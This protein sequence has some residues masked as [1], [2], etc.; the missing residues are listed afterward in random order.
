M[1]KGLLI[2]DLY[3]LK[4]QIRF[5][6]YVTLG[7]IYVSSLFV[8]SSRYGNAALMF[9]DEAV[10]DNADI[11]MKFMY[12]LIIV[13]T[14]FI[15]IALGE[16]V[17]ECFTADYKASF[18]KVYFNLP[19]DDYRKVLSRYIMSLIYI[20]MGMLGSFA[21]GCILAAFMDDFT[22]LM[23]IRVVFTLT[24]VMIMFMSVVLCV[25][26]FVG[27]KYSNLVTGTLF[28]VIAVP[29]YAVFAYRLQTSDD[30]MLNAFTVKLVEWFDFYIKNAD[31]QIF[32]MAAGAFLLMAVSYLLSVK[33][34]RRERKV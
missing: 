18:G 28:M 15:P 33:A 12:E 24:A 8:L 19:V 21:A 11:M 27:G 3:C 23:A 5:F 2:K 4:K 34:Q 6:I 30:D 1:M 22:A 17:T 26:Y 10:A 13:L 9:S 20:F 31:I 16:R 32:I 7:V 25:N 29:L 14:M